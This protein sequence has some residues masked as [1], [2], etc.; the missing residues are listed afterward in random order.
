MLWDDSLKDLLSPTLLAEGYSSFAPTGTETIKHFPVVN[1]FRDSMLV[2][3]IES[4][5]DG[6]PSL[7]LYRLCPA[8]RLGTNWWMTTIGRL[9]TIPGSR[10][11]ESE[12]RVT[13]AVQSVSPTRR[14]AVMVADKSRLFSITNLGKSAWNGSIDRERTISRWNSTMQ[15]AESN[16][17]VNR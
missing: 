9:I 15:P 1:M 5:E 2:H 6:Y 4:L 14:I 16:H 17:H 12:D 7:C 13:A 10:R 3:E 8:N 11:S